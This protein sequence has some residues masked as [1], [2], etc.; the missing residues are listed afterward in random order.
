MVNVYEYKDQFIIHNS[1]NNGW[2]CLTNE[3]YQE[4]K[5]I[6]NKEDTMNFELLRKTKLYRIFDDKE[7]PLTLRSYLQLKTLYLMLYIL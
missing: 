2:L 3:E 1:N 5:K 7:L 4:F 6:Q